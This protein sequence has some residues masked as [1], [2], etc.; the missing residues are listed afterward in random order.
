VTGQTL[1]TPAP[2]SNI[3]QAWS[4]RVNA[5]DS[6]ALRS[7]QV[8]PSAPVLRNLYLSD[9]TTVAAFPPYGARNGQAFGASLNG[10]GT[11]TTTV[12]G[13]GGNL[14]RRHYQQFTITAT[15]GTGTSVRVDSLI[16]SSAFYNTS[17]NT[18][19]AVVY[20]RS[21]FV[22][23][24]A[25]VAGGKGPGG[26]LL[27]GATGGFTAPILLPN[28]TAGLSNTAN[29]YRL[30][31][32]NSPAGVVLAPGQTLSIRL[33]WSSGSGSAG[34]Y[35]M[36]RDV[37]VKGEARLASANRAALIAKNALVVYPNPAAGEVT[38]AHAAA[39]AGAQI[40]VYSFDGRQ[41]ATLT[42]ALG[43]VQTR[44]PLGTLAA[45]HYLVVFA[46]AQGRRSA[47]VSKQ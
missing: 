42:P 5:Q 38:V 26:S 18:R 34:R 40:L 10:D 43:T 3:L 21:N 22:S 12:G 46:D 2:V 6:A 20:S 30:A 1:A 39:T 32:T 4:L 33:Y 16:L 17:S 47:A 13:P 41:I 45:G 14:S 37:E 27:T 44:L 15:G 8:L 7:A 11:W 29:R 24:S 28:Q 9:G 23:D 35:A 36:L 31:L 25:D 19:L